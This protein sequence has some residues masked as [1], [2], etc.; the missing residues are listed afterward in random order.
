M[1]ALNSKIFTH[2]CMIAAGTWYL[3]IGGSAALA[4]DAAS[5][6]FNVSTR[7]YDKQQLLNSAAIASDTW[8]GRSL[9]LQRCAY[10]H[11]GVGQPTY[12]TMG[13]WLGAETVDTFGET[14]FRIV[15]ENGTERM[16]G[17]RYTLR[18]EQIGQIIDFL[19]TVKSDQKPTA[20]QL[21]ARSAG[22][23]PVASGK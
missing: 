9:W 21:A 5:S 4:Q 11:D 22:A 15:T 7:V 8:K 12:N 6:P 3:T 19:K 17:F 16:P 13:P 1:S 18:P 10:C 20:A 2:A 14:A 23:A